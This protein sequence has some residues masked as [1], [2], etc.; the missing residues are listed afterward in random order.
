[1]QG[2]DMFEGRETQ[3]PPRKMVKR[4]SSDE[5]EEIDY[6]KKPQQ[7]DEEIDLVIVRYV[8]RR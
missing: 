3:G 7:S 4:D 1:M 5:E 6:R 8:T 2:H